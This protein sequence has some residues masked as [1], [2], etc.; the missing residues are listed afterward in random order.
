MVDPKLLHFRFC[1]QCYAPVYVHKNDTNLTEEQ[2]SKT[3]KIICTE[4]AN[5]EYGAKFDAMDIEIDNVAYKRGLPIT[6]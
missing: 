6:S 1:F 2:L 5:K 4:C 3:S